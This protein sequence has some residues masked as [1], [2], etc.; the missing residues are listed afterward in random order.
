MNPSLEWNRELLLRSP[1]FSALHPILAE[2]NSDSFPSINICN[3]LLAKRHAPIAM[4][5]GYPLKFVPQSFG[6]QD[7]SARY[8]PRCYLKGEVQTRENN[9]HDLLNALVWLTFPKAKNAINARHYQVLTSSEVSLSSQ[10]GAVRDMNT[11]FDES[12]VVVVCA[13][14][15]LLQ[16]LQQF[17]WRELFWQQRGQVKTEM[18][19]FLF[20]H[21]LYEKSL[22]PYVG[23]TGQGLV[24]KTVQ[25]F[26]AW[27]LVAQLDYLDSKVA[28]Y[29]AAPENCLSTRELTPVPLLGVPGWVDDNEVADFY[30]NTRYFRATRRG[31]KIEGM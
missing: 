30:A 14:E 15:N 13:D 7:F 5:S 1:F 8:E 26:F 25:A 22:H 23:L 27:P 17:K 6:K 18:R 19:F 9:W 16:L 29:I 11:L 31:L 12:G 3:E 10:R 21:G 4:T 2:L 28:D 24:L 20:G